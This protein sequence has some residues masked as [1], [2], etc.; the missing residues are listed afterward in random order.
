[1]EKVRWQ[2]EH[3]APQHTA[4]NGEG[5]PSP[6]GHEGTDPLASKEGYAENT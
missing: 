2:E 6:P 5:E 3:L 4:P 1:M